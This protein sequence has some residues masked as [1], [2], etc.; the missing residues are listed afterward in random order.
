MRIIYLLSLTLTFS[1]YSFAQVDCG[2]EEFAEI[3]AIKIYDWAESKSFYFFETKMSI[4][5]DGSPRA[6]HPEDIGLD[7]LE[8]AGHS[9]NWWALATDNNQPDGEPIIQQAGDPYPGYYV[10]M[11]ALTDRR[12][13]DHDPRKYVDA[14]KIPYFVLPQALMQITGTQKGD[15][16]YVYNRKTKRGTFAIFADVGGED[17]L[18]EGS[19]YLARQL[20]INANP[21]VGGQSSGVVFMVFPFSGNKQPRTLTEIKTEVE[22]LMQKSEGYKF[23]TQCIKPH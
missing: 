20:G 10:S 17:K 1:Y 14:E 2:K 3:A 6:Y 18:G 19:L 9:G 4:D 21:R 7:K 15:F 8:Y 23:L 12:Y 16:G 22:K 5:A 11:T 13:P